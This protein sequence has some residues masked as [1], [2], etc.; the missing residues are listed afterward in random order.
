MIPTRRRGATTRSLDVEWN[1][2][3]A[4]FPDRADRP[5]PTDEE[6]DAFKPVDW[7]LHDVIRGHLEPH[8]GSSSSTFHDTEAPFPIDVALAEPEDGRAYG[9]FITVG[10]SALPMPVGASDPRPAP[11]FVE[12]F[13]RLPARAFRYWDGVVL[14]PFE[15]PYHAVIEAIGELGRLP[16]AQGVCYRPPQIV[17]TPDMTPLVDGLPFT[18]VLL[19][20]G[21]DGVVPVPPAGLPGGGV[22]SFLAVTFLHASEVKALV[23][24]D[25]AQT[26][27][28][29]AAA[30]VNELFVAERA[31]V[32]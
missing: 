28:R 12:L 8:L 5:L 7:G 2:L 29:L 10:A 9:A 13:V 19:R 32:A 26:L 20:D 18:G 1:I 11:A 30:G 22:V 27:A 3:Y 14:E 17:A 4:R 31:A 24:A 15:D 21:A 23:G 25:R 16:H 6:I